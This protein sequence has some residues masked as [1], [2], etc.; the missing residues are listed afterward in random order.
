MGRLTGDDRLALKDARD[1]LTALFAA[2]EITAEGI[3]KAKIKHKRETRN[4][5]NPYQRKP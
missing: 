1:E 5:K 3:E 2:V 4:I